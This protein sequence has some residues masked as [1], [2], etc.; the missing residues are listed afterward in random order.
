MIVQI[1]RPSSG[2]RKK[3]IH[4]LHASMLPSDICL[5]GCPPENNITKGEKMEKRAKQLIRK[6]IT[7]D[8]V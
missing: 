3:Y 5:T 1:K 2:M 6:A 8:R 7:K 4:A